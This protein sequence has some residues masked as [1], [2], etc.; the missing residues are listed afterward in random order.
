MS[1]PAVRPALLDDLP[2][3]RRVIR[4]ACDELK[5]EFGTPD[6]S[7]VIFAGVVHGIT[8]N[9]AVV[10][11]EDAGKLVGFVA[12]VWFDELL[13]EDS[14]EGLGTWVAPDYRGSGLS[15]AMRRLARKR[16]VAAGRTCLSGVVALGNEAGRR[17]AEAQGLQVVGYAMRGTL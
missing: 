12:W 10:V 8:G 1:R 7:G 3:L 13:P 5:A 4:V 2:E 16:C 11:A 17:S 6:A 14:V 15:V 9:Q